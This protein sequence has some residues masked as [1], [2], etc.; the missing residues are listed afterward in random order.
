MKEKK[1]PQVGGKSAPDVASAEGTFS[2]RWLRKFLAGLVIVF[3]TLALAMW[4][5]SLWGHLS[6][7]G[8]AAAQL[9]SDDTAVYSQAVRTMETPHIFSGYDPYHGFGTEAGARR[10]ESTRAILAK[11][12]AYS[13]REKRHLI[14]GIAFYIPAFIESKLEGEVPV[15]EGDKEVIASLHSRWENALTSGVFFAI[16]LT[17]AAVILGLLLFLYWKLNLFARFEKE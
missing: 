1:K 12:R 2:K 16:H 15:V 17:I 7:V 13:E 4:L 14:Q 11:G 9:A 3:G 6:V 5:Y 10:F 8:P